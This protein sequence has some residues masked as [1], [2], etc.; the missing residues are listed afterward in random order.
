MTCADRLCF[1]P[2]GDKRPFNHVSATTPQQV[3]SLSSATPLSADDVETGTRSVSE[4]VVDALK[5]VA[6][7]PRTHPVLAM[8]TA[9]VEEDATKSS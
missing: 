5:F 3:R 7:S 9:R 6:K 8:R 2:F 1:P 4:V